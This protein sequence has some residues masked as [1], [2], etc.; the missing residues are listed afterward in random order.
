MLHNLTATCLFQSLFLDEGGQAE[1][2]IC[3]D[4]GLYLDRVSRIIDEVLL[5]HF[6]LL[7]N[8]FILWFFI[9]SSHWSFLAILWG[10]YLFLF[11]IFFQVLEV[12]DQGH[13]QQDLVK[14]HAEIHYPNLQF[15]STTVDFGCVLNYTETRKEI[16][17]T[18]CSPLPVT[19]RWAF[20]VDQ[21]H[22]YIHAD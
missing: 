20:Q 6:F 15:S 8:V 2:W 19:Y 18:N 10:K 4:P 21:K 17:I 12:N 22:R 5:M 9:S 7:W 13:P 14:L 16:C 1:F 11:D 3:C